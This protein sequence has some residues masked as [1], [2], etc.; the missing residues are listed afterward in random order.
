LNSKSIENMRR[1]RTLSLIALV[2]LLLGLLAVVTLRIYSE[3]STTGDQRLTARSPG[4][5]AGSKPSSTHANNRTTRGTLVPR[6]AKGTVPNAGAYSD[7]EF[8]VVENLTG[9]PLPG[10]IAYLARLGPEQGLMKVEAIEGDQAI[11][12]LD[13]LDRTLIRDQDRIET[14]P[15]EKLR[16][17]PNPAKP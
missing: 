11:L 6:A 8:L 1:R 9:R 13:T 14:M 15:P 5:E 12:S 7:W 3:D 16:E 2:V 4:S 17:K 10:D